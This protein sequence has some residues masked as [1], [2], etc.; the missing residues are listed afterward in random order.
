MVNDLNPILFNVI[1]SLSPKIL[2]GIIILEINGFIKAIKTV[3]VEWKP[4]LP[5]NR[6]IKKPMINA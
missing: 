4:R 1:S 5:E 6:S 2:C 3:A